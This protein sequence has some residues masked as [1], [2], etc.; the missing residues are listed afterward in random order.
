MTSGITGATH[1]LPG[2]GDLETTLVEEIHRVSARTSVSDIAGEL[3]DILGQRQ[4][5]F[6][7]QIKS[8]KEV[9]RWAADESKPRDE[10]DAR[11][12]RLFRVIEVLRQG[13]EGQD[14]IRAWMLGSN[15]SLQEESPIEAFHDDR[16]VQVLR[17][18]ETFI[19]PL[20]PV[21]SRIPGRLARAALSRA[22][23]RPTGAGFGTLAADG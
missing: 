5:A 20:T 10:T 4:V 21:A 6:A 23:P 16:W 3:Q 13:G 1:A 15:P 11:L 22:E 7:V 8:A 19:G 2:G 9:G 18:A 12:R 17:A 14:T